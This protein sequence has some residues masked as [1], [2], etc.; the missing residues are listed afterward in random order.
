MLAPLKGSHSGRLPIFLWK[1]DAFLICPYNGKDCEGDYFMG[2]E[3]FEM[4]DAEVME[5]YYSFVYFASIIPKDLNFDL[6]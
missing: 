3:S 1:G 2:E 6:L 5:R 4:D